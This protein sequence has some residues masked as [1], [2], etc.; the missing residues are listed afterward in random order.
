[1]FGGASA[2]LEAAARYA[3]AH[4]GG[5][6]GVESQE[7]AASALV[8]A[9]ANVAGVG[10]FS[11]REST[12]SAAWLAMEV[13]DG[14]LRWILATG[15]QGGGGV[16]G[17]GGD[18]RQGSASALAVAENVGRR[19]SFTSGAT[20]VTMYDLRGRGAAIL[21]AAKSS[22]EPSASRSG[23][24]LRVTAVYRPGGWRTTKPENSPPPRAHR[25][26]L[27]ASATVSKRQPAT[28]I[29]MWPALA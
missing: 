9:N 7:S 11:G 21:D 16:G 28:S 20:S 29:Q 2:S 15:S 25:V 27:S 18:G 26:P 1:M 5:A 24:S 19:V 17:F 8:A 22:A 23:D 14:R 13:R 12:V 6:V 3:Q 4:G 10:G